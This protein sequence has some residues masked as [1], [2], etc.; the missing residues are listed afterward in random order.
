M[1]P[2]PKG[3]ALSVLRVKGS[4]VICRGERS[5]TCRQ[6]LA[7]AHSP[8]STMIICAAFSRGSNLILLNFL[9]DMF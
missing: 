2:E 8:E 6:E 7:E 1:S 3:L 5:L 4:W 9:S